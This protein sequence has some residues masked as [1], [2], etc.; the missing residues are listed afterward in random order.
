MLK[1]LGVV[2]LCIVSLSLLFAPNVYAG[3]DDALNILLLGTDNFGY[4]YAGIGEDEE[5]SRADSIYVL[6]IQPKD[7]SIRL[8][9]IERDYLVELPDDIGPNK[10]GTS[11]YF[12][13]PEM[14][15]SAVNGLLDLDLKQYIHIDITKLIDAIDLFGGVD[16][17]VLPEELAGVNQFIA[18]IVVE[19][20]PPL[21]AGINHLSG[22][23]A[24]AFMG[25]RNHEMDPIASN[26]ERN[27]RQ[28]RVLSA[29]I[30]Q[31]SEKDLSTIL[32]LVSDVLPLVKTNISTAD[33]MKMMNTVLALP[34]DDIEYLRTPMGGYHIKRVNMHRVVVADN[35]QDEISAVHQYLGIQE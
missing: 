21:T 27:V 12:G 7:G 2:V 19:Q 25:T 9:G 17:E 11:T 28:K 20:V 35:M 16:V 14:A 3:T 22:L 4:E 33:L 31:A 18:G 1:R 34:L 24:W 6:S 26:A 23:Q 5:M 32:G 13:G 10:L 8:L 15:L 29:L 30:Q